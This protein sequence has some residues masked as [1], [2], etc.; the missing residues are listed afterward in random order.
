MKKSIIALALLSSAALAAEIPTTTD[1]T[2]YTGDT[3]GTVN[4]TP[5]LSGDDPDSLDSW[6]FTFTVSVTTTDSST[7]PLI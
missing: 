7:K 5:S 6:A 3:N 2:Y 1:V 4:W